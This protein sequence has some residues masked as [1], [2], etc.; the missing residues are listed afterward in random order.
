MSCLIDM[1]K[2]E[3]KTAKN[4]V[5]PCLDE[6]SPFPIWTLVPTGDSTAERRIVASV[7]FA[8]GGPGTTFVL[9]P[10]DLILER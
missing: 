5:K 7:K 2:V 6:K 4:Q 9:D 8:F 1:S 3:E 10:R